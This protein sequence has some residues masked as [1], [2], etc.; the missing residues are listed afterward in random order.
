MPDAAA[1]ADALNSSPIYPAQFEAVF[2]GPDA[3]SFDNA[4][5][6]IAAYER[7]LVRQSAYDRFVGGDV[8][9]FSPSALRGM[10]LFAGLGC[11][12]C[13]RDPSFSAA[14]LIEPAGVMKPFPI[15]VRSPYVE[16]YSLLEDKGAAGTGANT[17]LWRVPSLRNVAETAPYF[18]NGSVHSLREAVR[19]MVAAQLGRRIEPNGV[20]EAAP[21]RWDAR[22]RRITP[23][24]PATVTED[25][26]RD[27]EAFL[28]TLSA[29]PARL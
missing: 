4:S 25:D 8:S 26:I 28:R 16:R 1:V 22:Q 20:Y 18:H 19:V 6:A 24:A 3:V 23:L 10:A 9:V 5:A 15:F 17:G 11:R 12:A 14:G 13:H 27:L 29:P 21:G 7:R 2:G